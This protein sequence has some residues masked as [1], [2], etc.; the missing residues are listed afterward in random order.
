MLSLRRLLQ[1]GF[2]GFFA[3]GLWP[4]ENMWFIGGGIVGFILATAIPGLDD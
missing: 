2:I 4:P 3:L 1:G